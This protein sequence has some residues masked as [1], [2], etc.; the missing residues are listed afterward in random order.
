MKGVSVNDSVTIK[1]GKIQKIIKLEK[2]AK[3]LV[4]KG[5]HASEDGTITEIK[6][7]TALRAA[8]VEIEG[9]KGNTE[10]LLDNI[11]VTGAK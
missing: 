5:V 6:K 7:G 10:T 9:N 2:G 11:M 1:D 8:T 4:I 3:C